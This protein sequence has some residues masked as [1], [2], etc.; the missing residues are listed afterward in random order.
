[1][2]LFE[3]PLAIVDLE[4]TGANPV[5][6]RITEIGVIEV[7]RGVVTAEWDAL[8]NP[9][10]RIPPFIETLTGI[11]NAMVKDAPVFGDLAGELLERLEGRLFIAHNARFDAGFLRNEFRRLE[12]RFDPEVLCTVRLSRKLFPQYHKHNLDSLIE[13]HGLV[14]GSRHRAMGDARALWQFLTY[15]RDHVEGERLHEV[16]V[17]L[18]KTPHVPG[19]MDSG[20]LEGLP[21]A[22]GVYFFYGEN[23]ALLYVGKSVDLRSRVRSYF[24]GDLR[25]NRAMKLAQQVKRID[26]IETAGE[27]GALLLENRLIKERQ[28]IH[29][30]QQRAER[31]LC[32]WQWDAMNA[33]AT[34]PRLVRLDMVDLANLG[35]LYGFFRGRTDALN[36]LRGLAD[37]HQLCLKA[38]GLETA[39]KGPC[40]AHQIKRCRGVCEGKEKPAIYAA[41]QMAALAALKIP[42]WPFDGEIVI[43]DR[44]P[45]SGREEL[46]R[47]ENWCYLGSGTGEDW[48]PVAEPAFDLDV[49][50]IL[51]RHLQSR[52]E[53]LVLRRRQRSQ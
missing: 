44:H 38:L 49:Y 19:Q 40:F 33:P 7:D 16:V 20:V 13:R 50:R 42:A 4:T 39:G 26:W 36:A 23:D 52:P 35:N 14:C 51:Q 17:K 11:T 9:E 47:F 6:D 15:L 31:E 2:N 28:P 34:P 30:R 21:T 53:S 22:P 25:A 5:T 8:V 24:A 3:H 29:N 43:M 1:M 10:T 32:S 41:R 48:S 45:D 46:H 12:S 18:L 37:R 27:L